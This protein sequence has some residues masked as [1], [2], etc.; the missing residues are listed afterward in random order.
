[1]ANTKALTVGVRQLE[2]ETICRSNRFSSTPLSQ[3]K[4]TREAR[5]GQV[6]KI[7]ASADTNQQHLIFYFLISTCTRWTQCLKAM[8]AGAV[9]K[10][11]A[12]F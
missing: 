4:W 12:L 5:C 7:A 8:S 9:V 2:L 6:E 3:D 10:R 11:L 1:M